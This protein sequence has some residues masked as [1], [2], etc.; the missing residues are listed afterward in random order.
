MIVS[1]C[2]LGMC[3]AA[4]SVAPI[5]LA[6]Q[7]TGGRALDARQVSVEPDSIAIV[8][9]AAQRIALFMA[10][11]QAAWLRSDANVVAEERNREVRGRRIGSG[12][13]DYVFHSTGGYPMALSGMGTDTTFPPIV[14]SHSQYALCPSWQLG[15]SARDGDE[16][17]Y[18]DYAI[19]TSD[20]LHIRQMRE[21]LIR[22]LD[23]FQDLL[24][25]DDWIRMQRVRFLVDAHRFDRAERALDACGQT[26]KCL[27]LRGFVA[28]QRGQLPRADS[29]FVDATNAMEELDRCSWLDLRT[30]LPNSYWNSPRE[31]YLLSA[32]GERVKLAKNFWW[33]SD[34]LFSVKGNERRATHFARRVWFGLHSAQDRDERHDSRKAYGGDAVEELIVRYG[35]PSAAIW[36]GEKED[37]LHDSHVGDLHA[38]PYATA[39][40]TSGRQSFTPSLSAAFSPFTS[41]DS[42]WQ[43][44]QR[45]G[46]R[47]A[48]DG[49]KIWW[50][51]EHMAFDGRIVEMPLGQLAMLRRQSGIQLAI[52][53]SL[54]VPSDSVM[55]HLR[56]DSATAVVMRSPSPDTIVQVGEGRVSP[57]G[58]LFTSAMVPATEALVSIEAIHPRLRTLA[59]RSRFGIAPPGTLATLT[60]NTIAV[61]APVFYD[62]VRGGIPVDAPAM[63]PH[64]LTTTT[65][66][67]GDRL[68]IFWETYGITPGDSVAF[69]VA[70]ERT[71]RTGLLQRI[72]EVT[73]LRDV[74]VRAVGIAWRDPDTRGTEGT[75]PAIMPRS[76]ALDLGDLE[77]GEYR[78][79]VEA[80]VGRG[81]LVRGER[82]LSIV[83]R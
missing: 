52:T 38:G 3:I 41:G 8:Q 43:L 55:Q 56:R 4:L 36:I 33:L 80:R 6:A 53:H 82:A 15:P 10:R 58:A 11:W 22:T 61:S 66:R 20:S 54:F 37:R 2:V 40:Y 1:R 30:L 81:E 25:G 23:G 60:A 50:P 19:R 65:L 5:P 72:G 34:P 42:S 16:A 59:A 57:S 26:D 68:G 7:T 78:V 62:A 44:H 79:V 51:Y 14:S 13:C 49:G 47:D 74:P 64:M 24:P 39:E 83:R 73:R 32:C 46:M 27:S 70:V 35:P 76:V 48:I 77:P 12:H 21:D 31:A 29:L 71:T 28:Y 63:F 9:A 69:R 67:Q 45:E 17:W 75:G 18:P